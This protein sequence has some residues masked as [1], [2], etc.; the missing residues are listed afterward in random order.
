MGQSMPTLQVTRPSNNTQAKS[1]S[2]LA[3]SDAR[4]VVSLPANVHRALKL[5]AV[6]RGM[7]IRAYVLEVLEGEGLM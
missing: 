3:A 1:K 2:Q 6:E 4:L 7:T 5:R